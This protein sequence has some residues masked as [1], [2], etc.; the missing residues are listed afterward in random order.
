[1]EYEKMISAVHAGRNILMHGPAGTGKTKCLIDFISVLSDTGELNYQILAPTGTA[2]CSIQG[3]TIQSY[4]QLKRVDKDLSKQARI[5]MQCASSRYQNDGLDLLFI[6]EI[7]MVGDELIIIMDTILRRT[8]D[9]S[10]PFGGIRCV[11]SGDFYQ[12]AP[13]NQDWCFNTKIWKQLKFLLIEF[14]EQ[15]RYSCTQTFTTLNR[16]RL[17]ELNNR[18]KKW[19]QSRIQAYRK[20]EYKRLPIKPIE[21]YA[22]NKDAERVNNT[23]MEKIESELI[24]IEATDDYQ[25]PSAFPM[26]RVNKYLDE[27]ADRQCKIKIGIPVV[28][29]RNYNVGE[30][31][32]NGTSAKV[33]AVEDNKVIIETLSGDQITIEPKKYT[34][35]GRGW[36]ISRTQIPIRPGW[37]MTHAKSQGSTLAYAIIDLRCVYP[38]QFYTAISRVVSIDNVFIKNIDYKSLVADK[39][40]SD[41]LNRVGF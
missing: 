19:L 31:L 17:G 21:L 41:Y 8:Y 9:S 38:G 4:F 20:G 15:K 28:F 36:T 40:V 14:E 33:I 10:K 35:N 32:T 1:M 23:N 34:V 39:V 24:T 5:D 27:L 18:D 16:I 30:G 13:V 2:A 26:H 6:D 7:S 3:M 37:A 25:V 12:L 29:Y 11:V 22:N